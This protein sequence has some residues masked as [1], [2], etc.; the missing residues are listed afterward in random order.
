MNPH[1][2]SFVLSLLAAIL[3][4]CGGG[5]QPS[6]GPS[7]A[8][9]ATPAT[10]VVAP[11]GS[12]TGTV[13]VSPSNGFTG[14]VNVTVSNVPAGVASSSTEDARASSGGYEVRRLKSQV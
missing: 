13:T 8:I 7:F 10:L 6:Q 2:R 1:Y 5:G 14:S 12:N 11:G 4:S 9:A 3:C